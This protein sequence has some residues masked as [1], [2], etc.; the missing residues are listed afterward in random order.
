MA[1]RAVRLGTRSLPCPWVRGGPMPGSRSWA[2]LARFRHACARRH[3]LATTAGFYTIL[4]L[5]YPKQTQQG[6]APAWPGGRPARPSPGCPSMRRATGP[7]CARRAETRAAAR[8]RARPARRG[9]RPA[10]RATRSARAPRAPGSRTPAPARARG[11][12]GSGSAS[13][14]AGSAALRR[15]VYL[16][17]QTAA[18]TQRAPRHRRG[19]AERGGEAEP[20]GPAGARAS[21]RRV[22]GQGL[23]LGGR[24]IRVS[25]R[26][27]HLARGGLRRQP[28]Q[29]LLLYDLRLQLL[30]ARSPTLS[31]PRRLDGRPG[32]RGTA[33][34]G[35]AG[36][37]SHV[38]GA[39][40]R[41]A[42]MLRAP[43]RRRRWRGLWARAQP[44]PTAA[45]SAQA[46]VVL[47]GGALP[48]SMLMDPAKARGQRRLSPAPPPRVQSRHSGLLRRGAHQWC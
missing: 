11:G 8:P 44:C 41:S 34:H 10:W 1:G 14:R 43:T 45:G 5:P 31:L 36:P 6:A 23:R 35:Q 4:T 9:R 32:S 29:P 12:G 16:G 39:A 46:Y 17:R 37:C 42:R 38:R 7:R 48:H 19:R 47:A 20:G 25:G 13:R 15:V 24:S 28:P 21:D 27:P 33:A 2:R 18:R 26:W 40:R 22:Q 30:C 3:E